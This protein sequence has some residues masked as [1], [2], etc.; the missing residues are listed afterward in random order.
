[1]NVPS[2]WRSGGIWD[3]LFDD[4]LTWVA[5]IQDV[6]LVLAKNSEIEPP[7]EV[8]QYHDAHLEAWRR[9][10]TEA[11]TRPANGL[12]SLDLDAFADELFE[13]LLVIHADP[14]ITND[15]KD[16][17]FKELPTQRLAEFLGQDAYVADKVAQETLVTLSQLAKRYL[18]EARCVTPMV[19]LGLARKAR[20]AASL[21]TD[22]RW[23]D[24]LPLVTLY[25]ATDGPNWT[26][27]THWLSDAPPMYWEHLVVDP[28]DNRVFF[29]NLRR[30][31]LKG[32]IPAE[33]GSLLHLDTLNLAEN[34][35]SGE[36]PP[37][38]GNLSL[39]ECLDLSDNQL[40]G[41][42]PLELTNLANL[43]SLALGGNQF[44]GCIPAALTAV[45]VNDLD[46]LELPLCESP[47]D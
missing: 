26:D 46:A 14:D 1:M 38:L 34:Q 12:V 36:I 21:R 13:E 9:L 37:E 18:E 4:T 35:L 11:L 15:E 47:E 41:E 19:V 33:V 17:Y 2:Y 39:L 8:A 7:M 29:L 31:G 16:R 32:G 30:N 3:R 23:V 6:D 10:R 40:S 45:P 25:E 20:R 42:I 5:L 44:T 22:P 43:Q 28:N 27:N 24:V